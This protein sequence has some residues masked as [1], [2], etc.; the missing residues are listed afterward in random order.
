MKNLVRSKRNNTSLLLVAVIFFSLERIGLF[1]QPSIDSMAD[2]PIDKILF[3]PIQNNSNLETNIRADEIPTNVQDYSTLN[4]MLRDDGKAILIPFVV[5]VLSPEK[6]KEANDF[7]LLSFTDN[8]KT[9]FENKNI[10]GIQ[11]NVS[12]EVSLNSLPKDNKK[13]T[14]IPVAVPL[15]SPEEAQKAN[16][17]AYKEF[18]KRNLQ[19]KVDKYRRNNVISLFISI[20]P[21]LFVFDGLF[22]WRRRSSSKKK[23]WSLQRRCYVL[24]SVYLL[25]YGLLVFVPWSIYFGNS[26]QFPFIFQDFLNDNLTL[27]SITSIVLFAVLLLIPPI[28]SD[29]LTAVIS[30]LGLSV[31]IQSMFMNFFLGEINGVEPDWGQHSLWGTVNVFLWLVIVSA[32]LLAKVFFKT[33]GKVVISFVNGAIVLLEIIATISMIISAPQSVWKRKDNYITDASKQFQLSKEKNIIVIVFDALGSG[34]VRQGVETTPEARELLKDFTRYTDARSNYKYTFA[35]LHHEL[36]GTLIHPSPTLDELY[37][38]S[39]ESP[40][41]KSFYKQIKDSGYDSRLFIREPFYMGSEDNYH[42]YFSNILKAEVFY[43]ID[44]KKLRSC[45]VKMSGY[46]SMPYYLKRYFFYD[47]DFAEGVV[48]K[49]TEQNSGYVLSMRRNNSLFYNDLISKGITVDATSPVISFHYTT[50]AHVPWVI[51]ENCRLHETPFDT[52]LPAIRSCFLVLSELIKQLKDNN[53]YDQTMI[54]LC[55]DHGSNNYKDKYSTLF[56]M[57]FMIKPFN[58]TQDAMIEDDSTKVQSID[59]LPTLLFAACGEK[60]DL[61]S[62][63]GF[64]ASSVPKDRKRI[65]YEL[66]NHPDIPPYCGGRLGSNCL[67]EY[68]FDDVKTFNNRDTFVRTIPLDSD[69]DIDEAILSKAP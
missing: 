44:S 47:H 37:R 66:Y 33:S 31:Y 27:L 64:P 20:I 23:R 13:T 43:S 12:N 54:L 48:Q 10:K 61:S 68:V 32:P 29:Y 11:D 45:I 58:T 69:I 59:I 63:D 38:K 46:S 24:S 5:P 22:F 36:T 21:L 7:A 34:Y 15:L 28:I 50:G 39:W 40:S 2:N 35:G 65:V 4:P 9:V 49:R 26:V 1:A 25:L 57:S 16:E 52:P 62:F 67:R 3:S 42:D 6:A 53:I 17:K 14:A 51:D 56:D 30:G 55:S 18:I 8:S 19:R 60:A 41:A